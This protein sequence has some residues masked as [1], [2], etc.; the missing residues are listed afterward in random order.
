[1]VF[2]FIAAGETKT[3]STQSPT[4]TLDQVLQKSAETRQQIQNAKTAASAAQAANQMAG[5]GK[6]A[7][8]TI[9]DAAKEYAGQAVKP[10]VDEYDAWKNTL[11][12]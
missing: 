11:G 4:L 6:S 8:A 9:K 5:N 12:K 2:F 1:V 7:A 10:V 3:S